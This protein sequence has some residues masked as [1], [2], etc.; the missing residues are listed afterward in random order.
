MP[1][2]TQE[3][4]FR[5]VIE[6][7]LSSGGFANTYIALDRQFE[8]RCVV[9]ELAIDEFMSRNGIAIVPAPGR[10]AD[11][12]IWVQKTLR[13]AQILNK[14]RS[15]GVVPVRSVWRENGTV[16][17]AM[18]LIDGTELPAQPTPN[19]GWDVWEPVVIRLLYALGTIHDAGLVHGD[20]KPQNILLRHDGQPVLIDFGTARQTDETQKTRL[21]SLA[22]TPGYCPPELAVLDQARQVGPWSDLYSWSLTVMGLMIE[23]GG[24]G[25]APLDSMTRTEL[26]KHGIPGAGIGPNVSAQLAAAGIPEQWCQILMQCVELEPASRPRSARAILD[27]LGFAPAK[28]GMHTLSVPAAATPVTHT[29]THT[30]QSND[31]RPA[32]RIEAPIAP[33]VETTRVESSASLPAAVEAKPQSKASQLIAMLAVVLLVAAGYLFWPT[34]ACGN[35]T[36][37]DEESCATCPQDAAC[38]TDAD[39]VNATC[40]SRCGNGKIDQGETC[41]TC[42]DAYCKAGE[43]C[44]GGSCRIAAAAPAATPTAAGAGEAPKARPPAVTPPPK[45]AAPP[46]PKRPEV[47]SGSC[48]A[49]GSSVS[50]RVKLKATTKMPGKLEVCTQFTNAGSP[51]GR[52]DCNGMM[53][54]SLEGNFS[55]GRPRGSQSGY[56]PSNPSNEGSWSV[57]LRVTWSGDELFNDSFSL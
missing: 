44:E 48:S 26:A 18:D 57:R 32:T 55:R 19:T 15:E 53:A 1:D 40:V 43:L 10:E 47:S 5:F 4:G 12:A 37:D 46:K 54:T 52:W 34:D 16:Y 49:N 21:T 35:G 3:S 17:F 45:P 56:L 25:R 22:M 33:A 23:H 28:T 31:S 14:I 30:P 36:L 7:A 39:C 8:D 50:C 29:T 38:G 51:P 11:V 41:A 9:K 6:R 27:S 24:L 42:S 13:E 20:L 2:P